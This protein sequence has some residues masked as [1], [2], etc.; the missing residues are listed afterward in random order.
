MARNE[1]K[2]KGFTE[3]FSFL[4]SL[5]ANQLWNNQ[6]KQKKSDLLFQRE[7]TH[8][9]I[10]KF[11]MKPI[12]LAYSYI[13]YHRYVTLYMYYLLTSAPSYELAP[14]SFGAIVIL[15]DPKWIKL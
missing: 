11:D 13:V 8:F 7:R 9:E 6:L 5:L 3:I 12:N 15:S 1:I 4:N 14:K 2:E 10:V